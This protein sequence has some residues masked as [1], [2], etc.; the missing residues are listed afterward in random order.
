MKIGKASELV[1][2]RSVFKQIRHRRDE[3]IVRPR[4]GV[5]C[6]AI[7]VGED[8]AI[9]IST[10]PV[11][12]S[13]DELGKFA[14]TLATNN[15]VCSGAEP[16]GVMTSILLPRKSG[17]Q[18]IK[19]LVRDME[20]QCE[21]WNLE[22]V[23]GH[24]E[25]SSAVNQ[26]I[27][28]VTGIGKVKK[29]EMLVAKAIK[30]GHEIVM[31]KWA[32]L[33]GTSILACEK[34]EELKERYATSFIEDAKNLSCYASILPEASIA[35]RVGV[36]A[37]HDVSEG[38]IYEALWEMTNAANVGF[39]V[40]LTQIPLKQETIEVCEFFDL[41]PYMLMSS[42]S[43]LIVTEEGNR[44]VDELSQEGIKATVIGRITQGHGRMIANEDERKYVQPPRFDELYKVTEL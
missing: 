10:N 17:E 6:S 25:Y 28:T 18:T 37:M 14:I 20:E 32:G 41:N 36:I 5:D 3:V 7:H 13:I 4:V 22:I 39:Y 42:G 33:E 34:E 1:L 38:G 27:I 26:P 23:G 15:V 16:I 2:N 30:P 21:K 40:D 29:G 35:K 31:T 9:V 24:T 12:C 19:R 8:E 44:L 43:L 11:T